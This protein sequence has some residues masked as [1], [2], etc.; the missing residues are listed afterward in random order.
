MK[1]TMKKYLLGL[2]I[3]LGATVSVLAQRVP[4][5]EPKPM[6]GGP[7]GPATPID[8][9]LL[10]LFVCSIFIILYFYIKT[11]KVVKK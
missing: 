4:P 8:D 3:F 7:G 10:Y 9:Y 11:L 5:P 6:S 1:N 2:W